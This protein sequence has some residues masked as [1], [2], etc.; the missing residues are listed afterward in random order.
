M[1]PMDVEAWSSK[2][3]M[4]SVMPPQSTPYPQFAADAKRRRKTPPPTIP[5][6]VTLKLLN[7]EYSD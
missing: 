5:G 2:F 3:A 6:K 7:P 1:V 4:D